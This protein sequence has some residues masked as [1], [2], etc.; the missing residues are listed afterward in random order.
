MARS[1]IATGLEKL[2]S[3][4]PRLMLQRNLS[5]SAQMK[6]LSIKA[7]EGYLKE[8]ANYTT[9]A[10]FDAAA[11]SMMDELGEYGDD[12]TI[13]MAGNNAFKA[14]GRLK[15][16]FIQKQE[17][18][19]ELNSGF[20]KAKEL[21]ELDTTSG[22][23]DIY[24]ATA[25]TLEAKKQY[26]N[27]T[28]YSAYKKNL[29]NLAEMIKVKSLTN[30]LDD[31]AVGE[32]D[33][34]GNIIVKPGIQSANSKLAMVNQLHK[35]GMINNKDAMK[36]L[37][38]VSEDINAGTMGVVLNQG[39]KAMKALDRELAAFNM[40][41]LDSKYTDKLLIN[42]KTPLFTEGE[43]TPETI[44]FVRDNLKATIENVIGGTGYL[45]DDFLQGAIKGQGIDGLE[46]YINKM[47]RLDPNQS[48]A[49]IIEKVVDE[50][51]V[52]V[53]GKD[54]KGD[55]QKEHF[56]R[57]LN[58]YMKSNDMLDEFMVIGNNKTV[59]SSIGGY[60]NAL[61]NYGATQEPK[62]EDKERKRVKVSTPPSPFIP[63]TSNQSPV[64]VLAP[65]PPPAVVGG[66][67]VD[68]QSPEFKTV[69]SGKQNVLD[70]AKTIANKQ[71]SIPSSPPPV[72]A[73]K[74][75]PSIG[76]M[77]AQDKSPAAIAKRKEAER[78]ADIRV[79]VTA[80]EPDQDDISY[81]ESIDPEKLRR[82]GIWSDKNVT[83]KLKSEA[84]KELKARIKQLES[85]RGDADAAIVAEQMPKLRKLLKQFNNA[86]V[87]KISKDMLEYMYML[88][89][90]QYDGVDD[91]IL[92]LSDGKIGVE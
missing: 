10:Q 59:D 81:I 79:S 18:V 65:A 51:G 85:M 78:I 3:D 19:V 77:L 6:Q 32:T 25:T 84:K 13:A 55:K 50:Y 39:A 61:L 17:G 46:A 76:K 54:P 58:L 80:Q 12:P 68:E 31:L 43:L 1:R 20:E 53:F 67:P 56:A 34:Q 70:L 75:L 11:A 30:Y 90:S 21:N 47:K 92:S 73:P 27:S 72:S 37:I 63:S 62:K 83:D 8:A 87:N 16:N 38:E 4:L 7:T 82:I 66:T 35:V 44:G 23:N 14:L 41:G 33:E 60:T 42:F 86:G 22:L 26:F 5:E 91:F 71:K 29:E 89:A 49:D 24:K 45:T 48:T 36:Q 2:M 74:P 9:V 69:M 57:M 64:G 28:E 52:D 15:E 40:D 88:N